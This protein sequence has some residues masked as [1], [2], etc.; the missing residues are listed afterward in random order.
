MS[1]K[2]WLNAP[3]EKFIWTPTK[4]HSVQTEMMLHFA[5]QARRHLVRFAQNINTLSLQNYVN[6]T[7]SDVSALLEVNEN[8]FR[9]LEEKFSST[10]I[11]LK[12]QDVVHMSLSSAMIVCST[13]GSLTYLSKSFHKYK[14]IKINQNILLLN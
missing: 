7:L 13:L 8:M 11:E 9:S 4:L 14:K 2:L 5:S 3:K 6:S 1:L 10:Q 12:L